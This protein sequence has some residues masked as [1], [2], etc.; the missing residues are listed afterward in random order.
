MIRK[1][2]VI[3]L[4]LAAVAALFF[5]MTVSPIRYE[6]EIVFQYKG[7]TVTTRASGSNKHDALRAAVTTACGQLSSGMTELIECENVQPK[8]VVWK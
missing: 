2:A 5:Y 8:S 4:I 3:F 7:R 6:C 1:L